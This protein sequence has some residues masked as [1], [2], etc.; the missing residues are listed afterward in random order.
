VPDYDKIYRQQAG[1]YEALVSHEDYQG[2][3]LPALE[4]ITSLG[5][6]TGRLACLLAP[7]AASVLAFDLSTPMLAV[8]AK[9]LRA[10]GPGNWLTAVADH[11]AIPLPDAVADAAL[12]GWS[13]CYLAYIRVTRG[14][15]VFVELKEI[16]QMRI[17]NF[18]T[19]LILGGLHPSHSRAVP[20]IISG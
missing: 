11:R 12:S 4:R 7:L 6:G 19:T 10:G 14:L 16:P 9:R 18:S 2:N 17:S 8:A 5:A 1:E 13:L 20:I 3:I 15:I